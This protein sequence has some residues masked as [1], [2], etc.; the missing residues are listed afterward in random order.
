MHK[1]GDTYE[2]YADPLP[3]LRNADGV[4][5]VEIAHYVIH[6]RTGMRFDIGPNGRA[7]VS[8]KQYD[9]LTMNEEDLD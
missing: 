3:P 7:I 2:I 8:R 1:D 6:K 4:N 9:L 5:S